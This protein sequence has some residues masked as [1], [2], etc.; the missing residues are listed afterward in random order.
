M[1]GPP[2]GARSAGRAS[3]KKYGMLG[4]AI[5]APRSIGSGRAAAGRAA[6]AVSAR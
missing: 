2:A 3:G 6:A 4:F 5:E 1:I